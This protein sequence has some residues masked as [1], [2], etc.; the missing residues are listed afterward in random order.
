MTKADAVFIRNTE[1]NGLLGNWIYGATQITDKSFV[2]STRVDCSRSKLY[3]WERIGYTDSFRI[4]PNGKF[5]LYVV[6]D[7]KDAEVLKVP[8]HMGNDMPSVKHVEDNKFINFD[9][10]FFERIPNTNPVEYNT[11]RFNDAL[12]RTTLELYPCSNVEYK[13]ETN[14]HLMEQH[15]RYT[16]LKKINLVV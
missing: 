16:P 8:Y 11:T 7:K 9:K 5:D 12:N 6:C 3:Q 14:V 4:F 15:G 1:E 10:G 2:T 13:F